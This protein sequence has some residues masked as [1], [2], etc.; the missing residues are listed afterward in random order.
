MFFS[1]ILRLPGQARGPAYVQI[2]NDGDKLKSN[3]YSLMK[4]QK[5]DGI[6]H[7]MQI[8]MERQRE[9]TKRTRSLLHRVYFTRWQFTKYV[10]EVVKFAKAKYV[11]FFF[12]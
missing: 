1:G 4:R 12:F 2:V 6:P 7:R 10:T 9:T 3:F 8:M 5:K 11:S